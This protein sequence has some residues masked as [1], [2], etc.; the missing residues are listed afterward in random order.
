[1]I[2]I[3]DGYNLLKKVFPM[4]KGLFSKQKQLLIKQLSLY[5]TSK[6]G[7]IEAIIV[8]FDGGG[9]N[10]STKENILGISVVH[11]GVVSS[12]DDWIIDFVSKTSHRDILL[13]SLDRGLGAACEEYGIASIRV[14]DFY[15]L[16]QKN[17]SLFSQKKT[18]TT[19]I[20]SLQKYNSLD[21]DS[22]NKNDIDIDLLME[23]ASMSIPLK[24][25][26]VIKENIKT[27]ST[28]KSKKDRLL[29]NIIKKIS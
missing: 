1:M 13:V 6:I 22:E 21:T 19:E 26:S 14:D 9:L 24:D 25:S 11:A 12:A 4:V 16:M 2:I 17:N 18:Y 3:I 29:F 15:D 7:V 5:K 28:K 10:Y 20:G 27:R 23:Q 8:V